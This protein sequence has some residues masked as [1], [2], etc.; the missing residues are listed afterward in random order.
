M[1]AAFQSDGR[2]RVKF[3]ALLRLSSDFVDPRIIVG[4]SSAADTRLAE[5][6]VNA[7]FLFVFEINRLLRH[8]AL[9]GGA[10]R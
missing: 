7:A 9:S 2:I 4:T 6:T 8:S 5:L 10:Y 3:I 1:S